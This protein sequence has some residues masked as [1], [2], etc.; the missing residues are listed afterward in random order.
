MSQVVETKAQR[1]ERLKRSKNAWEHF[2]EIQE[3]A[4]KGFDSIPKRS[5]RLRSSVLLWRQSNGNLCG[6]P[7]VLRVCSGEP[8]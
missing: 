5:R 3:F 6:C 4:R 2:D 1:V 7:T 8:G